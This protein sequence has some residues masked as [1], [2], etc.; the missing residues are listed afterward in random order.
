MSSPHQEM[1]QP[2]EK[3]SHSDNYDVGN[4]AP[5]LVDVDQVQ[6]VDSAWQHISNP[7]QNAV[8]LVISAARKSAAVHGYCCGYI[9]MDQLRELFSRYPE[10]RS[11]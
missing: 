4:N 11:L 6:H 5:P 8:E 2:L 9:T 1:A 7:L 3:V 10:W